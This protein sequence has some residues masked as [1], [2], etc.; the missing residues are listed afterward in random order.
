MVLVLHFYQSQLL[1]FVLTDKFCQ[2]LTIFDLIQT[3]NKLVGKSLY[4][5]NVLALNLKQCVSDLSLPLRDDMD[6]RSVFTD[7]FL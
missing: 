1:S 2:L 5:I 3:L 7:S 4:P 6:I